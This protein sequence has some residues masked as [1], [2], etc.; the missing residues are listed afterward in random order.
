VIEVR[1][2]IADGHVVIRWRGSAGDRLTNFGGVRVEHETRV[3]SGR[4]VVEVDGQKPFELGAGESVR[5]P[6]RTPYSVVA[7]EDAEM[8]CAYPASDPKTEGEVGHL[9]DAR[10]S[11]WRQV[12][13]QRKAARV[14][15][16][17]G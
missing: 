4:V 17:R 5:L 14:G 2:E 8:R 6:L 9:R 7:V 10:G 1:D 15:T 13:A 16:S 11:E 12:G 3:V